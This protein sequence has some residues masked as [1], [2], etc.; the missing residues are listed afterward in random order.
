VDSLLD[1]AKRG[2]TLTLG[3]GV[4]VVQHAQTQRQELRKSAPRL[5]QEV[6]EA[7]GSRLKTLGEL[8]AGPEQ[9]EDQPGTD[10][11]PGH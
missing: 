7:V 9:R 2:L 4:L 6:N 5:L 11:A 10:P 1:V 3:I 8:V